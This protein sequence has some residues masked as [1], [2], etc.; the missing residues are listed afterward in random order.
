MLEPHR[1]PSTVRQ[2]VIWVMYLAVAEKQKRELEHLS[3]TLQ[4]D[5]LKLN[6]S[7]KKRSTFIRRDHPC[8]PGDRCDRSISHSMCPGLQPD[9]D[10][11]VSHSRK[12]DRLR[13]RNWRSRFATE[14]STVEWAIERAR[15]RDSFA[16]MTE[17]LQRAHSDFFEEIK[18]FRAARTIWAEVMRDRVSTTMSE[19]P[20]PQRQRPV[21]RSSWQPYNNIVRTALQ[22][23]LQCWAA[24]NRCIPTRSPM[25][26][27]RCRVSSRDYRPRTQQII[28][29]ETGVPCGCRPA[30]RQLPC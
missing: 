9:F 1:R 10:Q 4:N 30:R 26:P 27:M 23:L 29:H 19:V 8:E 12:R 20:R 28:A 14:L 5:I 22:G 7:L 2:P 21:A 11:R 24:R 16:P 15:R 25:K 3:G 13:Y 18:K 6:I 17:F